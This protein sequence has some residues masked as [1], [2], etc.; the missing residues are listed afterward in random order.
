MWDKVWMQKKWNIKFFYFG[1][2]CFETTIAQ[3]FISLTYKKMNFPYFFTR[4]K[5]NFESKNFFGTKK[6][7]GAKKRVKDRFI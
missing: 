2:Y 6:Y 5:K 4:H 7:A 1:R 3:T